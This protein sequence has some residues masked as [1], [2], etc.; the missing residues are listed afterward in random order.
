VDSVENAEEIVTTDPAADESSAAPPP[1][2]STA[3]AESAPDAEAA[4]PK[5]RRSS[6]GTS[7][8]RSKAAAEAPAAEGPVPAA[9]E[10]ETGDAP[11][12]ESEP[13]AKPKRTSTRRRKPAAEEAPAPEPV[14]EEVLA[15]AL[16]PVVGDDEEAAAPAPASVEVL[17]APGIEEVTPEAAPADDEEGESETGEGSGRGRRRRRRGKR[18]GTAPEGSDDTAAVAEPATGADAPARRRTRGP[19]RLAVTAPGDTTADLYPAV[20]TPAPTTAD[21]IAPSADAAGVTA[22]AADAP[23]RVRGPRARG[24]GV[25]AVQP[26]EPVGSELPREAPAVVAPVEVGVAAPVPGGPVLPA[27]YQPLPAEV[28]ARLPETRVENRSGFPELLVNGEPRLPLWFF[29]NTEVAEEPE[30]GL[31]IARREIRQAYEAGVRFFTVLSHL[32]WKTRSGERRFDLLDDI[33]GFVAENAPEALVLPRLIFSPPASW[34]RNNPEEMTLYPDGETGDV[35]IASRAFWE[36]EADGAL[37]AAVEHVAEGPHAHRVFG[38]YLEHG[39]WFFEKGRGYDTSEANQRG[40]RAWLKARYKNNLVALRAAWQDGAVTFD[41]AQ[42][43]PYPA[44]AGSTL[45]LTGR[46][47]RWADFHEY[48]SD[49]VAGVITR[50]ARAVKEASGGRSAVA[51]SYGYTLELARNNSGHDALREVLDSP[52]VD[53]LTGPVSYGGRMP[54]GSA[55]LPAPVESVHLA[56]KLWVSEDDTKTFLARRE[57]PDAYNP[58]VNTP[59]GTLAVHARNFGAAVAHG[60]GVSWMDLWGEGWLDD[61]DTWQGLGRLLRLGGEIAARRREGT[62]AYREPDVAVIVDERSYGAVR[63]DE[64]VLGHLISYQRDALLRSGARIGFYLQS[65]LLRP[66]FPKG[67][68][69]LLFLNAFRLPADVRAAIQERHAADGRTLAWVFGP[70]ALEEGALSELTDVI[71][72]QLR[73]QPWGSKTGTQVTDGRS[74][75]TELMRGQ[76]FGDEGRANPS[77]TVS[78]PKAQVF[79]EYAQ[80][81]NPSLAVR[82]HARWQSVFIGEMTLPVPLLRGLYRL[83]G[84]P[85]YTVDDDVAWIADGLICL[86]SA[87]G[88]GTTL[89]LPD[90]AEAGA[91][92][93]IYDL[94]NEETLAAGGFGARLSMPPRGTRLLFVGTPDEVSRLG[95][96]PRAAGPG[97]TREELPP[98]PAPFPLAEDDR[99][100]APIPASALPPDLSDLATAAALAPA[101]AS[102]EDADLFAAALADLDGADK[103]GTASAGTATATAAGA[104]EESRGRR[105]R[106]RRRGRG[107]SGGDLDSLGVFGENGSEEGDEE[108]EEEGGAGDAADLTAPADAI[109]SPVAAPPGPQRRPSLEELLPLSD[110]PDGAE[111]PPI[112]DEFLPLADEELTRPTAGADAPVDEAAL[113][114]DESGEGA[115]TATTG[116]GRRRRTAAGSAATTGRLRRVAGDVADEPAPSAPPRRRRTPAT[117]APAAPADA[118]PTD[119]AVPA[120]EPAAE[121]LPAETPEQAEA[122]TA[123]ADAAASDETDEA[124]SHGGYDP[125]A[126][127]PTS[128]APSGGGDGGY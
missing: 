114:T 73:L 17:D 75:L 50:L 102:A 51:V 6:S 91:E 122:A 79:G 127:G 96:D 28:L 78:D 67:P 63:Q 89:Y 116:R 55:P 12:V 125:P 101:G 124:P 82:R 42:V 23:K 11:A 10:P 35:S 92:S 104:D 36:G 4:A 39:E 57:T 106:R 68:K 120:V 24:K 74:P 38:F 93:V 97:L 15:P 80:S 103:E 65:D 61:R 77:F 111:L 46:E 49:A 13:A 30:V 121:D 33:L 88:G 99:V 45:F 64:H 100:S 32:P 62:I 70:G 118:E 128:D 31:E 72:M 7:S 48:G 27:P 26:G 83:A 53:I 56:G 44:P 20:R 107:R 1:A 34:E 58:K 94:L 29:V 14:A 3:A 115:D 54:G 71:G 108:D 113:L 126:Y 90:R 87:P 25:G 9:P 43:P 16:V 119:D 81:G 22:P 60:A 84:V 110:I 95:G 37:R 52:H 8:R 85:V 18:N 105:R 59:E 41:S 47:R 19:A 69:L 66:D 98:P 117:A 76:R 2:E 123:H 112:P 40:F 109:A 86:H 5:R 21:L